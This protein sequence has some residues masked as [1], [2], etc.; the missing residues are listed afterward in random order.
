MSRQIEDTEVAQFG[1][2]LL[3]REL[4][5]AERT[6]Y[7]S[8]IAGNRSCAAKWRRY[9]ARVLD[10]RYPLVRGN[11]LPEAIAE[12]DVCGRLVQREPFR[13]WRCWNCGRWP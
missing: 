6:V 13:K 5:L 3:L 8:R 4:A 7:A 1:A 10:W 2:A 9:R 12:C 11:Q